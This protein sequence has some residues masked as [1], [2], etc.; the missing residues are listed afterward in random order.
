M[1]LHRT[2]RSTITFSI[3]LVC[4]SHGLQASEVDFVRDVA[5]ILSSNCYQCHGPDE[6]G[7]SADLRLDQFE[8]DDHGSGAESVI[9][10]GDPAESELINRITSDDEDMLMPPPHSGKSLKPEQIETLKKWI[11]S[12]AKY[13]KHWAFT[14][15]TRPNLPA[16]KDDPW[17]RN[18]IDAFVLARLQRNA[19]KPSPVA[20]SETL[21]RRLSLD[22]IGLPP[23]L[24]E[25]DTAGDYAEEVD[26]LLASPHFGEHWGRY[27]LDAARY[28]DSDGFE[29]DK[30][31]QVWMYRDWVINAINK[32]KPYD[33]FVIDQIAGDLLDNPTQDELVATGFLRNSMINEEG[34]ADPEQF[35]MEALFDRMDAI[36]KSVL[37]LT[38]QCAQCHSHKYDPLKHTDYYRLFAFLNN[39]D[40]GQASVYTQQEQNQWQATLAVI[41]SIEGEIKSLY[42]DWQEM[43]AEWE[44]KQAAPKTKWH[45]L[46]PKL[47]GSGP[48]KHYLLKDGS[49]LAQGYAPTKFTLEFVSETRLPK[50]TAIRLELLN[51]PNLPH[52]GPGRSIF[53]LCALTEFKAKA[54]PLAGGKKLVDLKISGA[55][56]DVNPREE[57]LGPT[58]N[59][60]SKRRRVTGPV[61]FALDG[62]DKTAWG[63]NI[64]PGRSNVPRQAVFELAEPLDVSALEGG[65][66]KI[67]IYL[68]ANH[69]GSN[70]DDYQSNNLGCFRMSV[71][72]DPKAE[73]D[74]VPRAIRAILATPKE[75]RTS[76]QKAKLFSY[77]RTTEKE[78][79]VANQRIDSLWRSHPQGISQ[80][81]LLAKDEPRNTFR[82]DRGDFLS[83][84]EEMS[85][86]VPAFL[87]E[88]DVENPDRL[89][90]ARWLVD[91]QSPTTARAVINRMWQA[92]F[93]E[94][95]VP[96]PDDL[97]MQS[98]PPSHPELLDWL[99]VELMESGWQLKHIHRLI[100]DSATYRQSSDMTPE[101]LERDPTNRLM[102]RGARR[103][104]DAE[105]V[106]DIALTSSGLLNRNLG[107]PGVYPPAPAFLFKPPNSYGPK[108]WDFDKGADRYR[109]ALYTFH[110]RSVPYPAMQVFDAPN[111][112]VSCVRRVRSNTPLQALTTLNEPLF[113]ECAQALAVR[114]LT[115]PASE[116]P[117]QYENETDARLAFAIRCSLSRE[118][119]SSELNVLS[120][121]LGKQQKRFAEN[122]KATNELASQEQQQSVPNVDPSLVAAWTAT[123]RV[124]LNLDETITR[125]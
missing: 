12:G 41:N 60:Y 66:A 88:L 42:P 2:Y 13:A 18:P 73:A 77:W 105:V 89:D 52:G 91:R 20:D 19:L 48:E 96:T 74:Q 1:P 110:F 24:T 29:K 34:G 69:G 71:A 98:E 79:A 114:A 72:G 53:G 107:G 57:E 113:L 47:D 7:R 84:Q 90:L 116:L 121:F 3:L 10:I 97:G 23:T 125:E 70:S 38:L 51:N 39:C 44:A 59:D 40:E 50:I 103:R 119:K 92:Y 106:R 6:E 9:A 108:R 68:T 102:A 14:P 25:L 117:T 81:I 27:W 101:L 35:R 22:L 65:G 36:G 54:E 122:S 112:N 33:Q 46:R 100:V 94:G 32:D 62:D 43:L 104:V 109:R 93:G 55:T 31:R 28:A 17:V 64:G 120:D 99:A 5:P 37:G 61:S 8:S 16:T 56:A 82:L 49:I 111:R 124:L 76:K 26:R 30:P 86:G 67:H 21:I 15:P 123:A 115:Q 75:D 87:H 80:L 118:A 45:T 85:P 95:L 78:F 83:P 11:A 58:F 63:I 4:C